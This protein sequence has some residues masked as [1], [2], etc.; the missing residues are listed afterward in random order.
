MA[1]DILQIYQRHILIRET[2]IPYLLD[3]IIEFHATMSD[4]QKQ[5]VIT[6]MVKFRRLPK[7]PPKLT[8]MLKKRVK[9]LDLTKEQ[10]ESGA[11]P[12]NLPDIRIPRFNAKIHEDNINKPVII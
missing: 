5:Q 12:K 6:K 3:R 8:R 1:F 11:Y 9:D 4:Q 10:N 7:R 2:I